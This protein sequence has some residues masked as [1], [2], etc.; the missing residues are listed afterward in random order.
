VCCGKNEK[1]EK[2]EKELYKLVGDLRRGNETELKELYKQRENFY[3]K[4]EELNQEKAKENMEKEIEKAKKAIANE[5]K[6]KTKKKLE[7][8]TKTLKELGTPIAQIQ[9]Y[10]KLIASLEGMSNEDPENEFLK[11]SIKEMKI[12]LSELMTTEIRKKLGKGE[13]KPKPWYKRCLSFVISNKVISTVSFVSIP[14]IV[15]LCRY[16]FSKPARRAAAGEATRRL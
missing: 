15:N 13:E 8:I 12:L 6:A 1:D 7:E 2:D 5:N 9:E 4:Q 11:E 14:V 10:T 16:C 3:N